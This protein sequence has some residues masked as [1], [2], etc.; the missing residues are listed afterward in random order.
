MYLYLY[1]TTRSIPVREQL[2]SQWDGILLS[3]AAL[4]MHGGLLPACNARVS[5][6]VS[7]KR[8]A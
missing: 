5:P 2:G 1:H 7:E 4:G 8:D 6:A 3:S